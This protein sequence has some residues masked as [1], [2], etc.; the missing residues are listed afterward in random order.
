MIK[1]KRYHLISW[2]LADQS[3]V[4][5][6]NFLTNIVIA[7]FL[8]IE[9]FGI[10]SILLIV[11]WFIESL[12]QAVIVSPMLCL[13]TKYG[14]G[15]QNAYFSAVFGAQ[16]VFTISTAVLVA[17]GS[18]LTNK[19]LIDLI[20]PLVAL[21]IAKQLHEYMRQSFFAR[22]RPPLAFLVDG[23]NYGISI[24]GLLILFMWTDST[25]LSSTLWLMAGAFLVASAVGMLFQDQWKWRSEMFREVIGRHWAFG[26][27]LTASNVLEHGGRNA[28]LLIAAWVLGPA[29]IG[30]ER[31]TGNVLGLLVVINK[32]LAN[33]VPVRATQQYLA[34][35]TKTL[36]GYLRKVILVS[37]GATVIITVIACMAPEFWLTVL[38]GAQYTEYA[39]LIYWHSFIWLI[40]IPSSSLRAGLW[41]LEA[42]SPIFVGA[43]ISATFS[44]LVAYW[45]ASEFALPGVMFGLGCMNLIPLVFLS[46]NLCGRLRVASTTLKAAS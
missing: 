41:A 28:F 13:G 31:A 2:T 18:A 25:L 15:N 27:W 11:I 29:A 22:T 35:G 14:A 32:A 4:S 40:A 9:A 19:L 26:K 17:I 12:Q 21:V 38:Y 45:L 23:V 1:I 7:R 3:L 16:L 46:S 43:L 36:G 10:Y 33:L 44:V 24:I 8:G 37:I 5:G 34:G 30:A 6:A 20:P 42:T 39:Y